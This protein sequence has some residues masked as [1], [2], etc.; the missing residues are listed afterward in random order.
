M[1][2][3]ILIGVSLLLIVC[4]FS[5]TGKDK[6]KTIEQYSYNASEVV[7]N[8]KLQEKIGSWIKE[9]MTCYGVVILNDENGIPK[10][11]KELKAKVLIIQ[12]DKIK[13]KALENI[14]LAPVEGCSKIGMKKGETWW[15]T[16]GELY[17]S[18][19]DA[20]AF[21]DNNYPGLRIK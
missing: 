8:E 1:K 7:L 6:S 16:D 12:K 13:M 20:I 19:E 10:K 9:G 21:I 18:K 11:L 15:E 2:N 4:I 5:C 14:A 17:K 3:S